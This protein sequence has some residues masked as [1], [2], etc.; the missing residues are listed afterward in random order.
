M[1]MLMEVK[2][3]HILQNL[4]AAAEISD[5]EGSVDY[6]EKTKRFFSIVDVGQPGLKAK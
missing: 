2:N 1:T 4:D 3:R 5:F 6:W